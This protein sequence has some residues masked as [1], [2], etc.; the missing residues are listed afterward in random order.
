[1]APIDL[2]MTRIGAIAY[3]EK[4]RRLR[5]PGLGLESGI[6]LEEDE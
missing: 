5:F 3:A 4:D 2:G 1:M 6:G